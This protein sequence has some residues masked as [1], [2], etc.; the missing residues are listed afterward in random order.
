M[1]LSFFFVSSLSAK[2]LTDTQP[3]TKIILYQAKLPQEAYKKMTGDCWTN[4]IGSSR[5][6][7]WRCMA[8]TT[9]IDP[10]YQIEKTDQLI[11]PKELTGSEN[12]I[13]LDLN[14]AL[15]SPK[16][17]T[18]SNTEAKRLDLT[19]GMI[20]LP[21][22]G[23]LPVLPYNKT[24]IGLSYYC[25]FPEE[26]TKTTSPQNVGLMA[27]SITAGANWQAKKVIYHQ[28]DKKDWEINQITTTS[29]KTVWR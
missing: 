8:E 14:K 19:D 24:M 23:N 9:L 10:C 21:Y 6:D 28:N 25:V 1:S 4:S 27:E 26:K 15:P 17:S 2:P 18:F 11:C 16:T 7:A 3:T 22:T 13:L 29:I 5:A 12:T 20:C